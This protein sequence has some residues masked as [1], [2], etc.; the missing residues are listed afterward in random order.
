M[1]GSGSP[2]Q[3]L[4]CLPWLSVDGKPYFV[5]PTSRLEFTLDFISLKLCYKVV[6]LVRCLLEFRMQWGSFIVTTLFCFTS[7][8]FVTCAKIIRLYFDW[9]TKLFY[10]ISLYRWSCAR[11]ELGGIENNSELMTWDLRSS[12]FSRY[13]RLSC[14]IVRVVRGILPAV[15]GTL[16]T[17][18]LLYLVE[19][20]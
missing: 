3:S 16:G 11:A 4:T 15:C 2:K 7:W 18:S 13:D 19:R 14:S 8:L 10:W 17:K 6:G 9:W 12:G 20:L 1:A 5:W